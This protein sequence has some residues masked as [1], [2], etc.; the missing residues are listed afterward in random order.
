MTDEKRA[1]DAQRTAREAGT[2][3][4]EIAA[5]GGADPTRIVAD[6]DVLAADLLVG[7]PARDALDVV[8]EHSWLTLVA[9]E[10]LLADARAVIEVLADESLASDWYETAAELAELVE[11]PAEDHPALASA[12]RGGAGHVLSFDERLQS[13]Q[14]GANLQQVMDASVREP[15]A[16][17]T[18][19]DAAALYEA[20]VDGDY[21]GPDRDP[22]G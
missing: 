4:T 11:H 18:V 6:A 1:I 22:R 12:Y 9:S 19:F 13:V 16:F 7:G 20:V 21:P 8:R 3:S 15:R 14:A 10:H 5:D 2:A 17:T